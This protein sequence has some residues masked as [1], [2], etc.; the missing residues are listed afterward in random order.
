MGL[1]FSYMLTCLFNII[2]ALMGDVFVV[3]KKKKKKKEK[4]RRVMIQ[5][6][7]SLTFDRTEHSVCQSAW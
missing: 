7:I 5:T 4:G 3:A 1:T 2:N 6:S